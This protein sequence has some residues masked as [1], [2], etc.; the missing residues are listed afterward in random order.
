MIHDYV[1][2]INFLLIIINKKELSHTEAL[3]YHALNGIW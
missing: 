3:L 2:I 1:H